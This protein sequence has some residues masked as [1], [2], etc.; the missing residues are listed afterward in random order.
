MPKR[1]AISAILAIGTAIALASPASAGERAE[2]RPPRYQMDGWVSRCW[3][4]T[5][6]F[7]AECEASKKDGS[8][9]LR[10]SVGDDQFSQFIEHPK[11]QEQSNRIFRD[12]LFSVTPRDR[13]RWAVEAFERMAVDLAK[14]CPAVPPLNREAFRNPPD[15][16]MAGEDEVR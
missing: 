6:G 15:L 9:T 7:A 10:L 13:R 2:V 3:P 11:C 1:T 16:N 4:G 5:D 14:I 12:E 8:Y